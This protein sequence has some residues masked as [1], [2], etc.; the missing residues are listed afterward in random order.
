MTFSIVARSANDEWHG[1][2]VASAHMCVGALVPA[3]RAGI[4]LATQ[5]FPHL[6]HHVDGLALA[7]D[8]MAPTDILAALLD[9]D[10]ERELRQVGL[11]GDGPGV[12]FTGDACS[13]WS[14]HRVGADVAVLGCDLEGPEVIADVYDTWVSHDTDGAFAVRLLTA[15]RAGQD[16]GG[17]NRGIRS[18]GLL[19]VGPGLGY[20]G[21]GDVVVDLR[22][23][24]HDD[25]LFEL[26]RLLEAYAATF[27]SPG[28]VEPG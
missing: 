10:E 27:G 13:E 8:G 25:P 11:V 14:G 24:D 12:A 6:G 16:A 22:V 7:V 21:V 19:V 1:V 20:G 17:D 3:A 23:D 9:G 28:P 18:A 26:A 15:L 4:G 2:A 5:G